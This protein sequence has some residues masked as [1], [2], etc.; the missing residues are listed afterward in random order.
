MAWRA[1]GSGR[2]LTDVGRRATYIARARRRPSTPALRLQPQRT[3][4]G[5]RDY[6]RIAAYCNPY[7]PLPR[8]GFWTR[9][10]YAI[11]KRRTP[12]ATFH[13]ALRRTILP[14]CRA[15]PYWVPGKL[16]Y[17]RIR[18]VPSIPPCASSL[19]PPCRRSGAN[20]FVVAVAKPAL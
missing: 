6:A 7:S 2:V 14:V 12:A 11:I 17:M 20:A 15:L 1:C 18:L 8:C 4:A 16:A 13:A 3:C 19:A 9:T 10:S 5:W